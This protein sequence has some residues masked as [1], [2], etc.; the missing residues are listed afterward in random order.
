MQI[1]A[2]APT[3]SRLVNPG[4]RRTAAAARFRRPVPAARPRQQ[5][6]R[7]PQH[8]HADREAS[9]VHRLGHD[10]AQRGRREPEEVQGDGRCRGHPGPQ[11]RDAERRPH[12]PGTSSRH[13]RVQEVRNG[14]GSGPAR[15]SLR[16]VSLRYGK[17]AWVVNSTA[18]SPAS[19]SRLTAKPTRPRMP[20]RS[21]WR[22]YSA[23][24]ANSASAEA[25]GAIAWVNAFSG[26]RPPRR[27]SRQQQPATRP[28]PGGR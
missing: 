19:P 20:A 16:V 15:R 25:G 11:R 14:R 22:R 17:T 8:G 26:I 9:Q 2:F 7:Q 1:Y 3:I 4:F 24:S 10:P 6:G 12:R 27:A 21:R 5:R 28:G 23:V 18:N 13:D